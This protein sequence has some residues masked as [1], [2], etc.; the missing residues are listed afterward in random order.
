MATQTPDNDYGDI[1]KK[2]NVFFLSETYQRD[3][4]MELPFV[5]M[6]PFSSFARKNIGYMF[7]ISHGAKVIFDFDDDNLLESLE[8]G[9]TVP[10]PFLYEDVNFERTMLIKFTGENKFEERHAL[11]FNPYIYMGAS[12]KF[13]WPRG[14]PINELK[15]DFD[16]WEEVAN[17]GEVQVGDI[18]LSHVGVM[19]SLCN[20]DPDNDAVFRMTRHHF[21]DF[22]FDRSKFALPL[23]IPSKVYSPYNGQA[24]TF[25]GIYLTISVPGRV[26]DIW[27][28]YITQRI[29]K[30]LHLYVVCTPPIV[31]HERSAHDYLSD[32]VAENA[33]YEKT[34]RM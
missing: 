24:T 5:R 31:V 6:M 13:S 23:L 29:M 28:A 34:E 1:T 27:R 18:H 20:G 21:T 7:A 22:T 4:L 8:D 19:Q 15:A 33:L 9:E 26:T 10:P 32:M 16:K 3:H 17:G 14:F 11:A 25:W 30:E 2:D 12:H